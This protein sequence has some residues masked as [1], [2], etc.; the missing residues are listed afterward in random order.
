MK[1]VGIL[2]ALI[3]WLIPILALSMTQSTGA[4]FIACLIGIAISLIGILGVLNKAHL[5]HAIWKRG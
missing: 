3:G 1:I 5:E 4:R 2:L